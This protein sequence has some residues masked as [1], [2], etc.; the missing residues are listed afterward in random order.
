MKTSKLLFVI[1]SLMAASVA[2]AVE[3]KTEAPAG[4]PGGC[5][6]K[7]E[8]AGKTCDHPCCVEATAAKKNCEKCGGTN[9][10]A[11]K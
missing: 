1:A 10:A 2:F 8:K 4:K 11:K 6:V 9:V 7:A 5:C 3:A